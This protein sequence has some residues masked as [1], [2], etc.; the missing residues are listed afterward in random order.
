LDEAPARLGA[1]QD[2]LD[3]LR[4]QVAKQAAADLA[5]VV[6]GLIANAVEI[7]G[8]KIVIG[9][10]TG[11]TTD[12]VRVQADRVRQKLPSA[13]IT[14]GWSEA[15]DKVSVLV[16]LTNDM[17]KKGLKSGEIVKQLAAIVGGSGGGKPDLAQAGGKD[18]AK[19][20]DALKQA[21][22]IAKEKLK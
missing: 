17:V 20:G 14:F 9:Q 15:A 6:D 10:L 4:K 18:P 3:T 8:T 5:G 13:F 11:V 16:A 2:E 7:N 21:S 19:L 22:E 1:L 12:L